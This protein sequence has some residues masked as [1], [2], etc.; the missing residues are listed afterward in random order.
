MFDGKA[1]IKDLTKTL[2]GEFVLSLTVPASITAHF[3]EL[4]DKEL[5]LELKEWKERRSLDANAYF[6]LLVGK[7]AEKIGISAEQCKVNLVLDYGAV[8]RDENGD[9]V[10][11]KLPSSVNVNSIYKY[12]KKFDTRTENGKEFDCYI[13]YQHTSL[14]DTTE[15][16]KLIAGTVQEAQD[17]NIETRT[18]E[19]LAKLLSLWG[20]K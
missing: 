11:F 13:I 2:Q 8:M 6:H 9:K 12:A 18:P 19:E 3:D 16:S 20:T 10:G 4:K 17:L 14:L 7:I 15:M 5:R 1:Q